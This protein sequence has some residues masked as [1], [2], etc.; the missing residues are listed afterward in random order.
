MKSLKA[1]LKLSGKIGF[2]KTTGCLYWK[3]FFTILFKNPR[4]LELSIN[5][6]A[7]FIHFQ[8]VSKFIIEITEKEIKSIEISG[9]EKFNHSKLREDICSGDYNKS[10]FETINY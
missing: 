2:N 1:F 7:M 4:A 10:V 8:K 3:M 9:E 5:L 6:A